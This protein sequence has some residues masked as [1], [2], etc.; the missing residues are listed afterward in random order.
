MEALKWQK[1]EPKRK[2]QLRRNQQRRKNKDVIISDYHKAINVNTLMAFFVL[3][4]KLHTYF[5][6]LAS[7]A[8]IPH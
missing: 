8:A 4:V 5:D 2:R 7:R 1:K 3:F 6:C